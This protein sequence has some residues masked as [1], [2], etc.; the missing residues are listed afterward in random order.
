MRPILVRVYNH[1]YLAMKD[2]ID[3]GKAKSFNSIIRISLAR[4]LKEINEKS[5]K[6]TRDNK[7]N[8]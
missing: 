2:L 4:Y 1:Q 7:T 8:L 5:G 3:E 6:N